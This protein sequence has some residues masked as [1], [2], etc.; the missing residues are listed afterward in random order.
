MQTLRLGANEAGWGTWYASAPTETSPKLSG[1]YKM[2]E[3][4]F[5]TR[6]AISLNELVEIENFT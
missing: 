1:A 4:V 5:D 6:Y 2:K 3:A